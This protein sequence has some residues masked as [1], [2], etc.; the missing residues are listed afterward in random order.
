MRL[1]EIKLGAKVRVT[2]NPSIKDHVYELG[3]VE[4]LDCGIRLV[5]FRHDERGMMHSRDEAP[6]DCEL[7]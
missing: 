7:A 5:M 6:E 4:L 1:E 3:D 2:N